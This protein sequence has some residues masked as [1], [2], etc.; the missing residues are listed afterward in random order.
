LK[1][2]VTDIKDLTNIII[3][4]FNKYPLLSQKA[5]DFSF[6]SQIVSLQNKGAHLN[7]NGLQEIINI[8]ASMNLG[9]SDVIKSEFH[10]IN[11]VER[12]TIV[13]TNIPDPNWISG[14]VSGD[15][16]FDAGIRESKSIEGATVIPPKQIAALGGEARRTRVYLRF[17]IS[18]DARDTQLLE[19]II[20][21]FGVGR[22]EKE[23]RNTVYNL[24]IS[25]FSDLNQIIIPFFNQYP[26]NGIK[27]LDYLD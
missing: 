6:F 22:I 5:A 15:G 8:K 10:L 24:V 23:P 12:P 27:K 20:K 9:L 11:P 19:L 3:P 2:S 18:Q 1:Y 4:H 17:R 21:Y 25:K 16:N 13:T 14:F 26:L 7:L